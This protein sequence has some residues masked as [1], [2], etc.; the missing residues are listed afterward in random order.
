[1]RVRRSLHRGAAAFTLVEVLVVVVIIGV[2]AAGAVLAIGAAGRDRELERES[3]RLLA[4][5][6][7][8]REQAELQ[9]REYG[10][11]IDPNG[12]GFMSFDP[13]RQEWLAVDSDGTLRKRSLAAGLQP[14]LRVEGREV[15]LKPQEPRSHT[16]SAPAEK[17]APQVMLFSNGDLTPFEM[18]LERTG[19]S[20]HVTIRST[21]DGSLESSELTDREAR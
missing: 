6:R 10:L 17:P 9:T 11:H 20:L 14:R 4:V 18:R 13:R 19:T 3:E 2:L 21:E 15:V 12:Y 8:V 7:Y 16:G 1:M 5:L